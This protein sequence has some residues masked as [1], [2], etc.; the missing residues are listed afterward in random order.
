[1]EKTE[2]ELIKLNE[3]KKDLLNYIF[4][5]RE[6]IKELRETNDLMDYKCIFCDV[7]YSLSLKEIGPIKYL[8]YN[9]CNLC[10]SEFIE[11][12][13]ICNKYDKNSCIIFKNR[14][15]IILELENII[16]LKLNDIQNIKEMKNIE[17]NIKS[18]KKYKK[19]V[20]K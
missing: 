16:K 9:R 3:Y 8:M 20:N 5:L 13:D 19:W 1:M 11:I 14:E 12:F 17:N 10:F 15:N 4:L 6:T 2:K 7:C 18:I